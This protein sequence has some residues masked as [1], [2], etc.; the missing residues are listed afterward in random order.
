MTLAIKE[1]E[2]KP[3]FEAPVLL[4][5]DFYKGYEY[6]VVSLGSHP[7]AYVALQEGQPYYNAI[8]YDDV[9][10]YCHGG[11]TFVEKG[12]H[13]NTFGIDKRYTVIGWDYAHYNDFLGSYLDNSYLLSCNEV[14]KWTTEEMIEECKQVIGQLYV[15]EHSELFY[16]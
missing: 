3:R 1:M 16:K 9:D 2:Y 4:A 7:C 12:Y 5:K 6:F 11:C 10:I 14:K 15:L 13:N 8:N